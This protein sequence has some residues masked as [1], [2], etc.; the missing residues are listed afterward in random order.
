M[1]LTGIMMGQ[2]LTP[3]VA[4]AQEVKAE[5]TTAVE[6]THENKVGKNLVLYVGKEAICRL[7][8]QEEYDALTEKVKAYFT[9]EGAQVVEFNIEPAMELKEKSFTFEE[10]KTADEAYKMLTQGGRQEALYIAEEEETLEAIAERYGMT[11]EEIQKLNPEL[12]DPIEKGTHVKVYQG[13]PMIQVKMEQIISM[14]QDLPFETEVRQDGNMYQG[15]S[16]VL[17]EGVNGKKVI[18]IHQGKTNGN[19][20]FSVMNNQTISAEPVK[21]VVVEGTKERAATG[22]FMNPTTGRLTSRFGP[23]WGRM[24]KGIDVANSIGTSI[25]AADGGVVTKACYSG[26]Y[27]NLIEID[28][29]NGYKTRYAH[30][31]GYKVSVG[32]KVTQGQLIGLMGST[33]RSTGSHLHFEVIVD[34]V[35]VNPLGYVQY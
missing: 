12:V 5:N 2:T 18:T 35:Q 29:Q 10:V 19:I 25:L 31:S 13:C 23:R 24:H 26:S 33:G 20:D 32:D 8:S 28:H 34:N 17:Q 11:L 15:E 3:N 4:F 22:T 30:L 6:T 27:G 21:R 7:S 14:E 9:D 16:K 1:A